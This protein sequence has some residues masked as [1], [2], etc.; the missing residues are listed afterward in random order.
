MIAY[1][2]LICISLRQFTVRLEWT[3]PF[4]SEEGPFGLEPMICSTKTV[5]NGL[6]VSRSNSSVSVVS[7]KAEP[8]PTNAEFRTDLSEFSIF[9]A[10]AMRTVPSDLH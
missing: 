2:L 5:M 8:V 6:M 1:G 9:T 10:Q 7:M 3:V 4:T